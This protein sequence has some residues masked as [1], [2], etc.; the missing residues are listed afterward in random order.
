MGEGQEDHG[1][2]REREIERCVLWM[3]RLHWGRANGVSASACLWPETST[4][5]GHFSSSMAQRWAFP[6]STPMAERETT[7]TAQREKLA[8]GTEINYPYGTKINYPT[9]Q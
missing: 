1:Y 3:E 7:P 9:A 5:T 2:L 6:Q 8:H 4:A